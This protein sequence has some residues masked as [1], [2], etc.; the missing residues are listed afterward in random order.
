MRSDWRVTRLV[1]SVRERNTETLMAGGVG[2]DAE[3]LKAAVEELNSNPSILN[4]SSLSFLK[5]Y[6]LRSIIFYTQA[7]HGNFLLSKLCSTAISK[8]V[9][10]LL[11]AAWELKFLWIL[12]W[13]VEIVDYYLFNEI[14]NQGWCVQLN[15]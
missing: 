12:R 6:L 15:F 14:V 3:E 11:C 8:Y 1:E 4:S 9:T 10:Y 5:T 7:S 2:W 13:W